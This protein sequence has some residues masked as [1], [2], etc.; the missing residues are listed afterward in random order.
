[1]Q[2]VYSHKVQRRMVYLNSPAAVTLQY[3][4]NLQKLKKKLGNSTHKSRIN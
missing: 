3:T 1:M 2:T 4:E